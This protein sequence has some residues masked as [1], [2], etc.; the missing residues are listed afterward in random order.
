[1]KKN[2]L[3]AFLGI[4]T[5]GLIFLLK[6]NN[7]NNNNNNIPP[8]APEPATEPKT[9]ISPPKN[10]SI[11]QPIIEPSIITPTIS[12]IQSNRNSSNPK[13]RLT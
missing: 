5:I 3:L 13:V 12:N 11:Q 4:G 6:K 1:M 2:I 9:I 8:V 10:D 7:N